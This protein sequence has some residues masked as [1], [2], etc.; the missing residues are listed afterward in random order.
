MEKLT[1][2]ETI[3]L[4]QIVHGYNNVQ[5]S[6]STYISIHTVKAHISSIFK[7]LGAKNRANAVYIALKNKI[8]NE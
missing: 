6:K 3:I 7:K 2:Q 8:V 1:E 4:Q 5:I